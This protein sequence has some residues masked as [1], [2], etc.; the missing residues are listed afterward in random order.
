MLSR[1]SGGR[2][3]LQEVLVDVAAEIGRIVRIHRRHEARV[4]QFA[5][6]VVG[7]LREDTQLEVGQRAH[8]QRY[9]VPGQ[10]LHQRGVFGGLHAVVDTLDLQQVQRDRKSVV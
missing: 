6:V 1:E 5:Q 4:Q 7:Q 3:G 9:S 10:P 2:E 8:R